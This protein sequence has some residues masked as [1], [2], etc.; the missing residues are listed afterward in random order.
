M[1]LS[2]NFQP[3]QGWITPVFPVYNNQTHLLTSTN[4][5]R[6]N[7]KANIEIL[8]NDE[9]VSNLISYPFNGVIEINPSVTENYL[10]HDFN[11]DTVR[12]SDNPNAIKKV[13]IGVAD[14][15]SR[16]LSFSSVTYGTFYY[17]NYLELN[18]TTGHDLSIGDRIYLKKDDSSINPH[19]NDYWKVIYVTPSS[20]ALDCRY[21]AS[22]FTETGNIYAGVEFYDYIS[23]SGKKVI[24]T[25][26]KHQLHA[27]DNINLIMDSWAVAMYE[28][29]SGS[30]GSITVYADGVD[31]TGGAIP[32]NTSLDQ[33]LQDVA[34]AITTSSINPKFTAFHPSGTSYLYV[35]SERNL[36]DEIENKVFSIIHT[37]SLFGLNS[38]SFFKS[39]HIDS[40]TGQGWNPNISN[41][42]TIKSIVD[43]YRFEL[44]ENIIDYYF[45]QSGCERGSIIT[46]NDYVFPT[47]LSSTPYY[48]LNACNLYDFTD[49]EVEINKHKSRFIDS[50]FLTERPRNSFEFSSIYD[51]CTIDMLYNTSGATS[52]YEVIK[53]MYVTTYTG[54]SETPANSYVINLEDLLSSYSA[55]SEFR[56]LSFG[57]GAWNLNNISSSY[58][59]PSGST[60]I[61]TDDVTKYEVFLTNGDSFLS[62]PIVS[63]TITFHKKCVGY[64][65]YYQLIFL[66]RFGSWD[67]FNVTGNYQRKLE[68]GKSVFDKKR[69]QRLDSNNYGIQTKNRGNTV[70]NVDTTE[71]IKLY[72]NWLTFDE[73]QWLEQI[74]SSPEIY[75]YCATESNLDTIDQTLLFPV[76]LVDSE[77]VLPNEKSSMKRFEFNVEVSNKKINQRN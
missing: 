3:T 41:Y 59:T 25:T 29:I 66:N 26:N 7:Y 2:F 73:A 18:L 31:I 46:K 44:E 13:Q 23:Y 33:T 36:G 52:G 67:Y 70:F 77:I 11:Y 53:R 17:F 48:V 6:N 22:T 1:S 49:Y 72:S 64:N 35:Y 42:Y 34:D 63:E 62:F 30:S 19:Y 76:N 58:I 43:D 39:H 57:V 20:V 15:Y 47:Q 4:S 21:S 56:K 55:D 16:Q 38:P 68:L 37:G 24:Q 61:I 60:N 75:L 40:A 65:K 50:L 27:G 10:L 8:I 54:N 5:N 28:A 69:T 74:Y 32:Y 51:L 12:I 14:S 71:K 45:N 9:S